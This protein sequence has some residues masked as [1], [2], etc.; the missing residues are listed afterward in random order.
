[1]SAYTE[2]LIVFPPRG[3]APAEY[4]TCRPASVAGYLRLGGRDVTDN[5]AHWREWDRQ[6]AIEARRQ[7]GGCH[8]ED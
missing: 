4:V 3:F 5:A 7:S 6:C 1:M 2:H 8:W